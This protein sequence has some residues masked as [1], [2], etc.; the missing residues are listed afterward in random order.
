M[1]GTVKFYSMYLKK[2]LCLESGDNKVVSAV[3]GR[4]KKGILGIDYTREFG[5]YLLSWGFS[6]AIYVY[7]L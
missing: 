3:N 7:A 1:D 2:N 5:S 4:H 6:P